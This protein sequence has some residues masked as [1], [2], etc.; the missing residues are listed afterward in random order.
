M[1]CRPCPIA[2]AAQSCESLPRPVAPE[3]PAR[4]QS[5]TLTWCLAVYTLPPCEQSGDPSFLWGPLWHPPS[6]FAKSLALKR[7][8]LCVPTSPRQKARHYANTMQTGRCI[9]FCKC[10]RS[11]RRDH[12]CR[13]T[14]FEPDPDVVQLHLCRDQCRRFA[15]PCGVMAQQSHQPQQVPVAAPPT[16]VHVCRNRTLCGTCGPRLSVFL[17]LGLTRV[18]APRLPVPCVL[19]WFLFVVI[20]SSADRVRHGRL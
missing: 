5:L 16:P 9:Q 18:V 12:C 17:Q 10:Q 6:R 7:L 8:P 3:A 1:P 13:C 14:F 4:Q 15:K 2:A 11:C 19:F 20:S